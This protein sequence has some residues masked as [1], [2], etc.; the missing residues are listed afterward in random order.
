MI[1]R[2]GDARLLETPLEA[3]RHALLPDP[4]DPYGPDLVARVDAF[5]RKVYCDA[6][7]WGCVCGAISAGLVSGA[8]FL[9]W[10]TW[11]A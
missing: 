8:C 3:A 7:W 1:R 5:E 9:G 10:L 11:A 2:Y 6:W 4:H